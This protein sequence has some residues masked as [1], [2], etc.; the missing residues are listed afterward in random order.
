M[1]LNAARVERIVATEPSMNT[2][3]SF[4]VSK[5]TRLRSAEK[6]SIG[7]ASGRSILF[8]TQYCGASHGMRPRLLISSPSSVATRAPL[9]AFPTF[10]FSDHS[11]AAPA[12][13]SAAHTTHGSLGKKSGPAKEAANVS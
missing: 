8:T 9:S 13:A 1:S 4:P 7:M 3:S 12:A 2:D 5:K 10:V 6:S 11:P